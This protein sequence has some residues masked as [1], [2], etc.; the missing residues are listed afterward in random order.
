MY[1]VPN[2]VHLKNNLSF[3]FALFEIKDQLKFEIL[4]LTVPSI[5]SCFG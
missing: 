1:L 4:A 2:L 5:L 3:N